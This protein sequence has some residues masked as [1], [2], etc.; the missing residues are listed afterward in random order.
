MKIL[1]YSHRSGMK[2][3]G[4]AGY[5]RIERILQSVTYMVHRNCARELRMELLEKLTVDGWSDYVQINLQSR[6]KI[7]AMRGRIGLCLQTGNMGRFYADLLKL[8]ALFLDDIIIGAFYL[9]PTRT[10]ANIMS[11]NIANY[12]RLTSELSNV[13]NK[14]ITVPIV[15]IGFE[16][17]DDL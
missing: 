9:L 8:Q 11:D 6:I 14:V 12:E 17:E 4:K 16:N 5:L 1:K 3:L 15:V 2:T 13:F 10:C 7:T